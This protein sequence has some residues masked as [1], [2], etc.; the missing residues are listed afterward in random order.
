MDNQYETNFQSNSKFCKIRIRYSV[1]HNWST[2]DHLIKWSILEFVMLTL[3]TYA[4][5]YVQYGNHR[6]PRVFF[7]LPGQG[8][9][10]CIYARLILL[11][12]NKMF[13]ETITHLN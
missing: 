7:S 10:V 12:P 13:I 11:G 5:V 4:R 2:I 9:I 8:H 3:S 6:S 1:I